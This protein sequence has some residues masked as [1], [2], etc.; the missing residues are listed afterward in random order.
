MKDDRVHEHRV[1][2]LSIAMHSQINNFS[3]KHLLELI[4]H[5]FNIVAMEVHR[6]SQLK[7]ETAHGTKLQ[8]Q[9][10]YGRKNNL[11]FM[12]ER[13]NYLLYII[14]YNS[15]KFASLQILRFAS[16]LSALLNSPHIFTIYKRCFTQ[17]LRFHAKYLL[18]NCF[19][20][21]WFA[22]L[23]IRIPWIPVIL[24]SSFAFLWT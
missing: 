3:S 23:N 14:I 13:Q 19:P 24:R 8:L 7:G 4:T 22:S 17:K 20:S 12:N 11:I 1:N 15:M 6:K 16:A 9:M 10:D 5:E 18:V 21:N 2:H